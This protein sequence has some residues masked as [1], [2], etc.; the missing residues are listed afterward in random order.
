M[1]PFFASAIKLTN[2]GLFNEGVGGNMFAAQDLPGVGVDVT[3]ADTLTVTWTI[4]V[5]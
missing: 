1:T 5:G 3:T 2:S 4:T